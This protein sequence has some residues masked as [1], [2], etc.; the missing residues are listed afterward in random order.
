M[1]GVKLSDSKNEN[2]YME[3]LN[4]GETVVEVVKRDGL[5]WMGHE[6]MK[7]NDGHVKRAWD[8]KEDGKRCKGRPKFSRKEMVKKESSTVG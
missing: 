4:L 2:E 6:L 3:C 7:E 8:L 5:R 1:F